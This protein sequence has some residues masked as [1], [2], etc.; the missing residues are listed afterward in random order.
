MDKA[1]SKV[2]QLSDISKYKAEIYGIS[3]LWIMLFHA[4]PM[5]GVNYTLGTNFLKPLDELIGFGN[6]GVE[7]F[8]FCSGIFLYF[9]YYR[10]SDAYSF[11]CKRVARLFWP[12]AI[13]SGLYW[14]YVC[15]IKNGSVL[16]FVSKLTLLDFW[17]SGDQQ[18]WFVSAIFLFYIIY[19][20]IYGFLFKAKFSNE[21]VRLLILLAVVCGVTLAVMYIYPDYYSKVEI[22][23]TRLPVFIIGCYFGKLVYE[24]KTAPKYMYIVC[25]VVAVLS[26]VVLHFNVLSGVWKRWFYL[27]GGIPMTFVLIWVLNLLHSKPLN[28]FFAFFGGISLN[29][30]VSHVVVIRVYKLLP[31]GDTKRLYIYLLLLAVSV[32][33]GWLAELLIRQITKPNI[34]QQSN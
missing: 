3:I 15:I 6:M 13:I 30:Y 33:V 21:F 19:P 24:K 1:N 4:H 2:L 7:I 10:N 8:L 32:F 29:L 31:F 16:Q 17:I 23:L 34:K 27:V 12:V 18:I 22:A 11:M 28:K 20:Y 25:L 5:F 14:V 9:S 26:L